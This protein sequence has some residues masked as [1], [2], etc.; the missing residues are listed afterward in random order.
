MNTKTRNARD[1]YT[2]SLGGLSAKSSF[3]LMPAI[4]DDRVHK[5]PDD[6]S[7]RSH[8]DQ[9][10]TEKEMKYMWGRFWLRALR[11]VA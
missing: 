7:R 4:A 1:A 8:E 6:E 10:D 2:F 5:A 9:P 3:V 11:R